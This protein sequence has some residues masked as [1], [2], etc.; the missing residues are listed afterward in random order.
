MT[1]TA[2]H[3][4]LKEQGMADIVQEDSVV[5]ERSRVAE[6]LEAD[7]R[8]SRPFPTGTIIA[9][10]SISPNGIRYSYAAVFASGHWYTT[11][12]RSNGYVQS[13]MLHRDLMDYFTDRGDSIANLRVA[14]DFEQVIL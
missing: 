2:P 5:A 1:N 7:L 8:K 12:E 6:L 10:E 14:T 11:V 9:W 13:K 4:Y 3:P